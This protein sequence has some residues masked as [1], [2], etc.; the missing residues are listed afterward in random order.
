M[1][2]MLI[3]T[4]T[5]VLELVMFISIVFV[6]LCLYLRRKYWEFAEPFSC[7]KAMRRIERRD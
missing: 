2:L 7:A 4:L 6:P 5:W 1:K 3:A